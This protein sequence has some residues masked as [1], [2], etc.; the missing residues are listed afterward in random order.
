MDTIECIKTRMSIRKFKPDAVPLETLIKVIDAAKWSPSYKNSQPWEV[1]IISGKK[2]QSLSR[3][4][5]EL[6]EKN[7]AS[8][9]DLPEPVSW[10]PAIEARISALMEKR[11]ELTG[12]D[13]NSP[14]VRKQSKI[15]NF[16]FYGAPHGIFLFQDSSLT[17]WSIFDM[18]LFAHGL[19]LA[20]HAYGLGTVPQAFLTDY[21]Q[22]VKKFLGIHELK[23]L[24]LGISIGYPDLE[25]PAN[26]FRTNRINTDEI[27]RIV[28]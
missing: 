25:S 3:H 2:K 5:V 27:V 10:P 19:M 6:I 21:A 15:A 9:P 26:S 20:A 17:V 11:S 7:T 24:V 1:M 18:G 22:Y 28:E 12:K 8:C 4:L 16:E 13:L 23:R 14:E